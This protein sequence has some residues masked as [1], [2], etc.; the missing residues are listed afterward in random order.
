MTI[1]INPWVL[2]IGIL[3]CVGKLST[4]RAILTARFRDVL[5]LEECLCSLTR[6]Q[7]SHSRIINFSVLSEYE[8]VVCWR[9]IGFFLNQT[10]THI[11]LMV[12]MLTLLDNTLCLAAIEVLSRKAYNC[13]P[14][15]SSVS[16][17]AWFLFDFVYSPSLRHRPKPLIKSVC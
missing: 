13:S 4:L 17:N 8:E 6:H 9:H 12:F 1:P 10:M 15:I 2:V 7:G 5:P 3:S 11:G 16:N 14:R